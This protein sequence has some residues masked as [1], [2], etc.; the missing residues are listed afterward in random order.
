V[1]YIPANGTPQADFVA[2]VTAITPTRNQGFIALTWTGVLEPGSRVEVFAH[3]ANDRAF[4]TLAATVNANAY[5]YPLP[6]GG[7]RY[8]WL[9]VRDR[10]GRLSAWFPSSPTGGQVGVAS[11]AILRRL[12]AR[13]N[14]TAFNT[15]TGNNKAAAAYAYLHG[16]DADGNA[17][18]I[19]GQIWFDG[20][21]ITVPKG[22][23]RISQGYGAGSTANGWIVLDLGT[24][25]PHAFPT[26]AH[27]SGR[28]AG[29]AKDATHS[30][31]WEYDHPTAGTPGWAGFPTPYT[32]SQF[33]VIGEYS[34]SA[35][36][37]ATSPVTST[38]FL[39][40]V[41]YDAALRLSGIPWA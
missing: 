2:P 7:T 32:E 3:T 34:A 18:D 13:M 40:A 17:A 11:P 33:V 10:L 6:D 41:M 15:P 16:Y 26:S 39:T 19:D 8:F 1:Q 25:S 35:Y 9:R 30:T 14:Y 5:N 29:A 27:P 23:L 12:G 20:A 24:R 31:R 4:A 21:L 38:L 28:I 22:A 36:N 37:G